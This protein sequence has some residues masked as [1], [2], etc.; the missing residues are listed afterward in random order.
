MGFDTICIVNP[1]LLVQPDTLRYPVHG[2]VLSLADAVVTHG[3]TMRL[4]ID[5]YEGQVCVAIFPYRQTPQR[6]LSFPSGLS[7]HPR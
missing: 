7:L 4:D 2:A 5:Q 6:I 3:T 1:A